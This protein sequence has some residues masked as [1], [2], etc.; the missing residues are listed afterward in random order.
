MNQKTESHA[1]PLPVHPDE[2][3]ALVDAAIADV[4]PVIH[5][6]LARRLAK[7]RDAARET[8]V[9]VSDAGVSVATRQDALRVLKG[10]QAMNA[11]ANA[12]LHPPTEGHVWLLYLKTERGTVPELRQMRIDTAR[13][14]IK[15]PPTLEQEQILEAFVLAAAPQI[16]DQ[17]SEYMQ[18][19]PTQ[20]LEAAGIAVYLHDTGPGII[21]TQKLREILI[22]HGFF[23]DAEQL[24]QRAQPHHLWVWVST[25]QGG[26]TAGLRQ[27]AI[28][29][30]PRR[31]RLAC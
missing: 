5:Q 10:S 19:N 3:A 26:G 23:S 24:M 11:I 12:L 16:I 8:L 13:L 25:W 29:A 18:T 1:A 4:S 15:R 20:P 2:Q 14:S 7:D 27:V 17:A 9:V 28:T 6:A 30:P 22:S 31:A 21:L